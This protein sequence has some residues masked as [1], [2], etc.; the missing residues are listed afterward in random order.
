M[1]IAYLQ[2]ELLINVN[3]LMISRP[4]CWDFCLRKL[5]STHTHTHTHTHKPQLAAWWISWH[6]QSPSRP[7]AFTA[8]QQWRTELWRERAAAFRRGWKARVSDRNSKWQ[9]NVLCAVF[10]IK[11]PVVG[12]TET[13]RDNPK[14]TLY[15][16][17]TT[18]GAF[19]NTRSLNASF[20]TCVTVRRHFF[21]LLLRWNTRRIIW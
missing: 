5:N 14:I 8:A 3:N 18:A 11:R 20:L 6:S 10:Y 12:K 4:R 15:F 21:G 16:S 1:A 19:L 17:Q 7:H 9:R 13:H 2:G